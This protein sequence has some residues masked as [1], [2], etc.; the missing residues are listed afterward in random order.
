MQQPMAE[1]TSQTPSSKGASGA[2][3]TTGGM[4]SLF[5]DLATK[6]LHLMKGPA[7][8]VAM[9]DVATLYRETLREL[10]AL[11][12][13]EAVA[14]FK[15]TI[16]NSEDLRLVLAYPHSPEPR[17]GHTSGGEVLHHLHRRLHERKNPL[18]EGLERL[19][20]SVGTDKNHSC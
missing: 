20:P 4:V 7:G 14:D 19:L 8:T 6:L 5:D 11:I 17:H 3:D 18:I 2:T 10:E 13:A 1:G 9:T 16:R 12:P 15:R